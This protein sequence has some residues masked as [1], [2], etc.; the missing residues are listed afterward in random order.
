MLSVV[1]ALLSRA[2]WAEVVNLEVWKWAWCL[3]ER[4][5]TSGGGFFC[6]SL[7]FSPFLSA[8]AAV[9][10][11]T[12]SEQWQGHPW[13][14]HRCPLRR[15][16]LLSQG[17]AG[18]P[19]LWVVVEKN[20]DS[21]KTCS[22]SAASDGG[23]LESEGKR[24]KTGL[25][26]LSLCSLAVTLELPPLSA[27]RPLP[28]SSAVGDGK[29]QPSRLRAEEQPW[30]EKHRCQ[31]FQEPPAP[32]V[33]PKLSPV[34]LQRVVGEH[35][36]CHLRLSRCSSVSLNTVCKLRLCIQ[37]LPRWVL[38]VYLQFCDVAAF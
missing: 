25:G 19:A 28:G 8:E 30:E 18:L 31:R 14:L 3:R 21:G 10:A 32:G 15:D 1:P 24:L 29:A 33:C 12:C 2:G 11:V 35:C 27:R 7:T 4:C 36:W 13:D 9:A 20:D 38:R 37:C 23:K 22:I 34:L 6:I 26:G 5:T 17:L 16:V